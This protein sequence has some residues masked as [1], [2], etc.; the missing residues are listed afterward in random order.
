MNSHSLDPRGIPWWT[1]F[2]PTH[3]IDFFGAALIHPVKVSLILVK[4]IIAPLVLSRILLKTGLSKTIE[5]LKGSITNWSFFLVIYIK[6]GL[7]GHVIPGKP[8]ELILPYWY[9]LF[10]PSSFAGS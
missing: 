3:A 1:F 6:T 5:P 2:N 7:N 10:P 8:L 9:A 4:R